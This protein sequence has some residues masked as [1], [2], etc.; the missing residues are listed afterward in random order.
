MKNKIAVFGL[1]AIDMSNKLVKIELDE[2]NRIKHSASEEVL[3]LH[4]L[5]CLIVS[6]TVL[7][8]FR[9]DSTCIHDM[10]NLKLMNLIHWNDLLPVKVFALSNHSINSSFDTTDTSSCIGSF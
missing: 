9:P 1:N 4:L 5:K 10:S 7:I 6:D 3:A 2:N 8:S